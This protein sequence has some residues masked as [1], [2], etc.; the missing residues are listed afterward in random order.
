M[1]LKMLLGLTALG[2]VACAPVVGSP[3]A[4][5]TNPT[6]TPV[7]STSI[8]ASAPTAC[9]QVA[10]DDQGT[11][12]AFFYAPLG[13]IKHLS[14]VGSNP[15]LAGYS[16]DEPATVCYIDGNIPKGPPPGRNG[17]VPPSYDRD[18]MVVVG[19]N[20]FQIALGYKEGNSCRSCLTTFR[21]ESNY[22]RSPVAAS[23]FWP[24]RKMSTE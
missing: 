15:Q 6:T 10:T 19:D 23:N 2:L 18:V 16:D 24:T 14:A 20:A 11:I 7:A 9:I 12:A 22:A 13:A 5:P 1:R 4:S 8:T 17:S 3:T 21:F